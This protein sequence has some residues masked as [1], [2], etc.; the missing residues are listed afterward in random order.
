[1]Q[2]LRRAFAQ[3][4]APSWFWSALFDVLAYTGIRRRQLVTLEWRDIDFEANTL[5]LRSEGSKTRVETL[6]PMHAA[7]VAAFRVLRSDLMVHGFS[8]EPTAQV[9]WLAACR[10]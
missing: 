7:V 3:V 2:T 10:A 6:V 8:P 4:S 5:R 9:F 1:M